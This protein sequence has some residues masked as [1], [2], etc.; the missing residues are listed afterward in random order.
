MYMY[1]YKL[2]GLLSTTHASGVFGAYSPRKISTLRPLRLQIYCVI[3]HV[4]VHVFIV[5]LMYCVVFSLHLLH[6]VNHACII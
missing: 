1:M 3:L 2:S 6:S 5:L 4:H